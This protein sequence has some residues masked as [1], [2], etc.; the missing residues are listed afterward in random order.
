MHSQHYSILIGNDNDNLIL[1]GAKVKSRLVNVNSQSQ[2]SI[3]ND[4]KSKI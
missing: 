1:D 4:Y 2:W 3:V